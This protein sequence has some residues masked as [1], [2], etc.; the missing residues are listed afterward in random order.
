[1]SDSSDTET[2][3]DTNTVSREKLVLGKKPK[4]SVNSY[5]SVKI[6]NFIV[7]TKSFR[8]DFLLTT[9]KKIVFCEDIY[10]ENQSIFFRC[11]QL[12]HQPPLFTRPINA[13]K[14]NYHSCKNIIPDTTI[15]VNA[16][17]VIILQLNDFERKMFFHPKWRPVQ[18]CSI[19]KILLKMH[20][21][22]ISK[23]CSFLWS[24]LLTASRIDNI[25]SR[26]RRRNYRPMC[27]WKLA[28]H[29]SNVAPTEQTLVVFAK[30]MWQ[31]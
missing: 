19:K 31:I 15:P 21:V 18:F 26:R 14:L 11:T 28:L 2:A 24:N 5:C 12:M 8:D 25:R 7:K 16:N 10:V 3:A 1:M 27:P 29:T 30:K 23:L 20:E 22:T 4:T 6:G 17:S 9:A 13:N